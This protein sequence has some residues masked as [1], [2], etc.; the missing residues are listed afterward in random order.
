[1]NS[2]QTV[3]VKRLLGQWRLVKLA[4]QYARGLA[5]GQPLWV[6]PGHFYS[7][8]PSLGDLRHHEKAIWGPLPSAP[9]GI[10]MCDE[11]QYALLGSF[12]AQQDA[13]TLYTSPQPPTRRLRYSPVN[14]YFPV[15][16]AIGLA[17]MLAHEPPRRI[18]EVGSGYSSAVMLDVNE[19]LLDQPIAFTFIDPYPDRLR[20]LLRPEDQ[21]EILPEQVQRI[22]LERF[23]ALAAG[24]LL[25]IDSSHVAKTGGDVNFLFFEV[26]PRLKPGVRVHVHDIVYPFEY[27]RE[28]SLQGRAWN[29]S[30]LLR[31]FLQYNTTYRIELF[32]SYLTFLHQDWLD[33]RVSYWRDH[34]GC[35]I[36]LRRTA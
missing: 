3:R 28:W 33:Q 20:S 5:S 10:D 26:L 1:V 2:A 22:P 4:L 11:R 14:D 25:F 13:Q 30:Y 32:P 12:A 31:A 21:A 34:I 35:S 17:L 16:D 23:E 18:I 8:I 9:A 27:S 15:A 29:E 7:P 36:W 24:D 19:H 6:A